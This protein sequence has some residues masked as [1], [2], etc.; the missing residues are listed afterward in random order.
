MSEVEDIVPKF[1]PTKKKKKKRPAGDAPAKKKKPVVASESSSS[2]DAPAEGGDGTEPTNTPSDTDPSLDNDEDEVFERVVDDHEYTYEE[3]LERVF[4]VLQANNPD[5]MS[6]RR[7]KTV[8]TIPE[9]FRSTKKT[10]W[11]NFQ[12]TSKAMNRAPE[13]FSAFISS[14]LGTTSQIDGSKRLVVNGRFNPRQLEN[15]EKKYIEEYIICKTCK[16][17]DTN[18]K[19]ENRLFF[20]QCKLCG[21]QRTVAAVKAGYLAQVGRRKK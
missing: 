16:S 20:V 8:F 21:S 5:L 12:L 15:V 14:E 11:N 10:V 13:H 9:V 6:A 4:S 18:L 19:K 2:S 17:H 3:L 1:D 7:H